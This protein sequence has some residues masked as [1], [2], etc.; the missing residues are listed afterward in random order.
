MR[1]EGPW[2]GKLRPL[3]VAAAWTGRPRDTIRTWYRRGRL[4]ITACDIRTR[5]LLVDLAEVAN[6]HTTTPER[7]PD[8][9]P[10]TPESSTGV[11]SP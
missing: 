10:D 4:T 6:L 11:D 2:P 3:W 7:D 5:E 8:D 1:S 9:P